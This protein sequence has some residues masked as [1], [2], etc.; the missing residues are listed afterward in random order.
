MIEGW[1][2]YEFS[3]CLV[4][5]NVGRSNQINA[6]EIKST[7]KYPVI[8]QGQDFIAGYTDEEEKLISEGL[9]Y[10][11]FGDHTRCFKYVDFPFVVGADGTKVLSPN[12]ELFDPKFFFFQL[13]SFD[14]PSRGYN[15]HY[16]LLKEKIIP[17]PE[18]PEQRKIAYVL[19]TVQK[20]IEQ[21]DKL[22]RTTTEL[23]KALMQKLFTEGIGW[24]SGAETRLKQTEIGPVPESWEVVE[25]G[26]ICERISV[27][28]Q[29]NPNG[30]KPYVGL[31]HIISGQI[32]LTDWGKEKEVV[33]S[34][35]AFKKGHIL[36]GKLRPYLDKAVIAPIDGISS[37]DILIF[38][39]KNEVEND[40][41]IHFFHTDRFIEFAKS[42]TSGVQH[43]RTSWS[44]LKKIKLA[45]PLK[46]ERKFIAKTLNIIENKIQFHQKKKQTLAAL[47]KTLLHE[48]MTGQRRVHEIE[49]EALNTEVKEM[50]TSLSL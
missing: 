36:Y 22:I 35:A 34:K 3:N 10:I 2:K 32:Y 1:K 17:R 44:S 15:R 13:L 46:S 7:G 29:P 4:D 19:S 21:Q 25:L 9:P 11:I 50:S 47:F 37:T 16:K 31:E 6:S 45:L 5:N 30:N 48:L 38:N 40:F 14:I 33:S 18:L 28:V 24:L 12:K 26:E 41:L 43:P 42:T 23:K 20:A 27:N 49:F 39:G 8:D